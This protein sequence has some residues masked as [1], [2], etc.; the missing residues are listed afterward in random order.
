MEEKQLK[1]ILSNIKTPEAQEGVKNHA[2]NRAM[3]AFDQKLHI[4][5]QGSA[6]SGRLTDINNFINDVRRKIMQKKYVASGLAGGVALC[7]LVAVLGAPFI[8]GQMAS[9]SSEAG[10]KSVLT[11]DTQSAAQG[12]SSGA[13]QGQPSGGFSTVSNNI[14]QSKSS[15]DVVGAISDMFSS[16]EKKK[17]AVDP[18]SL[19]FSSSDLERAELVRAAPAEQ[20]TQGLQVPLASAKQDAPLAEWRTRTEVSPQKMQEMKQYR[21]AE[22]EMAA[23]VAASPA[24][25]VP[26]PVGNQHFS[27]LLKNLEA[28]APQYQ[29]VIQHQYQDEG[30]DK[31]KDVEENSIKSVKAEPVSTFSIDVDTASYGFMRR[32]LNNGVLPQKDAVRIEELINYF[33]YNYAIPDKNADPFLPTIAV[34]DAP[35]KQGNKIIHVGIKGYDLTTKPK[36]NLVF[37]IDTSGSMNSADKL[38]LL[39]NSFKMMLDNLQPDDTVGIVVYAGSAGTVLEPTKAIDKQ[40]IIAALDQLQAGG[41]TAG[42]EG[43][44][45]AYALA[46]QNLLKDGNNRIILASDGDFNVG[47]TNPQEL[48]D[49]VE[50]KR[51]EGISLSV[52][53]FGQGN[54]NDHVMQTL[55]QNGNGNAAYIDN[56]NEARKVLVN[57]ANSTLFTIAKDVKIQVEFN[58]DMV[59]EYRLIGYE[60]R[61]L[62][63]EDFNNDK[64]DAGE[65]GAGATVTAI[66]EITPNGAA[67][68]VDDLRY[69]AEG[70]NRKMAVTKDADG[71]YAFLKIRSKKPDSDTSTLMTR[72]ITAKD[73]IGFAEA[74]NDVRFA[75]AVAGFGQLLKGSKF[76][77]SLTYDQVIDM[78]NNAKGTDEFG[79]RAEFVNLVRLAKSAADMSPQRR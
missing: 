61:H 56:L 70:D 51:G 40:K 8:Q 23:R 31:F 10:Q 7:A 6:N 33:D 11:V 43:I 28:V 22:A 63:R 69:G 74:S 46:E 55:A 49:F 75:A 19:A 76:A 30:R 60:T 18:S 36:S 1:D 2:L 41:S 29:D 34:Y 62:N 13:A 26:S 38:P 35:W 64:V 16:D 21:Q 17:E 79:Y 4:R 39:V 53:G 48:Q 3:D 12:Q 71:E 67:K 20:D 58:P 77:G 50:R 37:L 73:Q 5:T 14:V 59:S 24:S 78:A 52:L 15:L 9:V 47:I 32:Q 72:P 57:E 27:G 66:Y 42:G 25:S 45:Q 68:M 44:R 54:Y 65:V